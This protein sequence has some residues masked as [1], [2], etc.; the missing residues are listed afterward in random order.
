MNESVQMNKHKNKL[1]IMKQMITDRDINTDECIVASTYTN[2]EFPYLIKKLS[3]L[4]AMLNSAFNRKFQRYDSD[5]KSN[6]K[7]LAR[8][9]DRI[10][11]HCFNEKEFNNTHSHIYLKVPSDLCFDSVVKKM[12]ELFLKLDDRTNPNRKFKYKIYQE[13]IDDQ[14]L[15]CD[16]VL[17]KYDIHNPDTHIVI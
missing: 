1:M 7:Y 6:P 13:T 3:L 12:Q 17:K 16:Y 5:Q 4:N 10:V 15:Y 8:L 11:F 9:K 14:F 2:I